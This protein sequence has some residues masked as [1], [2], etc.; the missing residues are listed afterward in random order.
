MAYPDDE[1]DVIDDEVADD[2]PPDHNAAAPRDE[3]DQSRIRQL[4]VLRRSAYRRRSYAIIAMI[5]CAV[6][7][8][9]LLWMTLD[10]ARTLGWSFR[11]MLYIAGAL[12]A[13][14]G[15]VHF[16]RQAIAIHHEARQHTLPD[17]ATAPDFTP[18]SDGRDTWKRL[19]ELK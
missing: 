19:E 16:L 14:V 12:L 13:L 4:L 5:A 18:L 15:A 11:P 9:Q 3:L 10:Y 6:A 7:A 17:P 1:F 8:G 2:A